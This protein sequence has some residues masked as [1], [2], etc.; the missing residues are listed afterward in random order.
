VSASSLSEVP[1]LSVGERLAQLAALTDAEAEA[2]AAENDAGGVGEDAA[3]RCAGETAAGEPCTMFR[4]RGSLFC[5]H[6]D[7]DRRAAA[8]GERAERARAQDAA[9]AR[10]AWAAR[11]GTPEQLAA[12]VAQVTRAVWDR[13]LAHDDDQACLEG[14]RLLA[15]LLRAGRREAG[16]ETSYEASRPGERRGPASWGGRT[17]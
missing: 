15:E 1:A 7:P 5:Y 4:F 10:E 6:H 11:L 12:F 13:R 2:E 8:E 14:A 16:A 3:P 17:S 9:R